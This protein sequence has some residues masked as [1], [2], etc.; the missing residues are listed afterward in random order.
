MAHSFDCCFDGLGSRF[1]GFVGSPF[2]IGDHIRD[3]DDRD[4]IF[5]PEACD[6]EDVDEVGNLIFVAVECD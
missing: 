5:L 4:V 6:V 3:L 2:F 1:D